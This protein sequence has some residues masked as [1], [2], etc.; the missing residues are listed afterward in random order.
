MRARVELIADARNMVGESAVWDERTLTLYW[1]DIIGQKVLAWQDG[2]AVKSWPMPELVTSIG[3]CADNRVILGLTKQVCLWDF[4]NKPT[5]VAVVEPDQPQT[6]LNEGVVGPDGC[7]WVGTMENNI[8]PDGSPRDI[9]DDMGRLYRVR[10]NGKVEQL[11]DDRFGITN[12][13]VWTDDGR[14]ITADTLKNAV[15]S[16]R[17]ADAGISDRLT[18]LKDFPRGL[19]DG[20]CRD[21]EGFL[22]NCRVAGGACLV[23]M[24][25]DGVVDQVVDLPCTWPTSCAFGGA[26]MDQLFV[27]SARF[28]MSS[29]HLA[30][31]PQEGGLF[32]VDVSQRG[33]AAHRFSVAS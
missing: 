10:P 26:S 27:T 21:A 7:L 29:H 23:R 24:A 22:W 33:I 5:V 31:H 17:V 32:R 25:P 1:V 8:G 13:L 3:L 28:T 6:R 15:Y 14:L 20:S 18:L 19:P 2:C 11:S 4:R 16:Y 12:T 30:R 9:A